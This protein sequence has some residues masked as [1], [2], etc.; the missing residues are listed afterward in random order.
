MFNIFKKKKIEKN[1]EDGT[2]EEQNND[3]PKPKKFHLKSLMK[4]NRQCNH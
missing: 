2:Q 3:N 1:E 4:K